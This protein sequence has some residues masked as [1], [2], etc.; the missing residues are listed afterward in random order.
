[1]QKFTTIMANKFADAT[2][3]KVEPPIEYDANDP[4]YVA[5]DGPTI[6]PGAKDPRLEAWA[7]ASRHWTSEIRRLP[8]TPLNWDSDSYRKEREFLQ[9]DP[10]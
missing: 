5:N 9:S 4:D 8:L 10:E 2:E 3:L 6:A 1:M 7:R